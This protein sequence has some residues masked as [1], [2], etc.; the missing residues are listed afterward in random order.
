MKFE[1]LSFIYMF[2]P[3]CI[4]A[5]YAVPNRFKNLMLLVISLTFYAFSEPMN[6]LL[7]VASILFD[8]IMSLAMKVAN[9]DMKLRKIALIFSIIKNI[10]LIIYVNIASS[11]GNMEIPLGMNIYTL[12]ALGY[13]VEVYKGDVPYENNIVDFA[14]FCSFFGKIFVGPLVSYDEMRLQ[15]K[16]KKPSITLISNGIIIFICGLFKKIIIS[17]TLLQ[18]YSSVISVEN[19]VLSAWTALISMMLALYFELS[20]YCDMARGLANIFSFN[21]PKNFYYPYQALSVSDFFARFN[22]TIHRFIYKHVYNNIL[23]YTNEKT[24]NTILCSILMGL[25]FKISFNFV[26]WGAFLGAFIA[27]EQSFLNKYLDKIP[28]LFRR[29]YSFTV[30]LFSFT[31][32]ISSSFLEYEYRLLSLLGLLDNI[33]VYNNQIIYILTTN[34]FI[35][36]LSFIFMTSL[37]FIALEWLEKKLPKSVIVVKSIVNILLLIIVTSYII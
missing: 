15:I 29:A 13:M 17:S 18:V 35:I 21:L 16:N 30:V 23:E 34:Y 28:K 7:L 10:L 37:P 12:T 1:T 26:L 32:F 36:L 4:I 20:S 11:S 24:L 22:M 31:I 2:L 14:L 5:Y 8:Y 3:V 33:D 9:Q 25:W 19:S 27:L 6:M